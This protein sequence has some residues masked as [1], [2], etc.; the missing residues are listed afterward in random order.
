MKKILFIASRQ[1]DYLQDLTYSGLVEVAGSNNIIDLPWNKKYHLPLKEYP[2][3]LGYTGVAFPRLFGFSIKDID[4]VVLAG[5]KKDAL[6]IYQR[7]LPKIKDKL[8]VFIDGGDRPETGGDFDR[9]GVNQQ[10]QQLIMERPFDIIFKREYFPHLHGDDPRIFPFPFS[11][12][13]HLKIRTR[14]EEEKKYQVSFW[15]QQKPAIREKALTILQNRYDCA[16]NGTT[17]HQDF[18][19]YKRKGIFYLEELAACKIVLNFRGG[20]WDTMRYWEAV[21]AGA[22]M[23]SQRPQI[24]IPHNFIEGE[25]I[26][27]CDD[28]LNDLVDKIDHY[29]PR[30]EER[31]RIA[32][33]AKQHLEQFHLNTKRAE[34]FLACIHKHTNSN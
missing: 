26:I 10:Y 11:F 33:A 18:K 1:F 31:R 2:K 20:G 3:N 14:S 9:L 28:S 34:Y 13:H 30:T 6:D 15:G 8:L 27:F 7:L 22:F 12:P 29:L 4:T 32:A 17:L 23:I 16:A 24:E 19:T 5:V 25:H 21:A